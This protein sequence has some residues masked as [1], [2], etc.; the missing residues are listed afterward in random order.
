MFNEHL[1]FLAEKENKLIGKYRNSGSNKVKHIAHKVRHV[2]NYLS[3]LQPNPFEIYVD[4][5]SSIG[6]LDLFII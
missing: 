4:C 1:Q 2:S 5:N 6:E 3:Y